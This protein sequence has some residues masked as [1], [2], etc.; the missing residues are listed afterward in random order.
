MGN[1]TLFLTRRNGQSR[2]MYVSLSNINI[3]KNKHRVLRNQ[4]RINTRSTMVKIHVGNSE[5]ALDKED[6][7]LLHEILF[8]MFGHMYDI[9]LNVN[10]VEDY[11]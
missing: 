8:A 2:S 11:T 9:D 3:S 6:I 5:L 4:P 10:M 1:F 7:I